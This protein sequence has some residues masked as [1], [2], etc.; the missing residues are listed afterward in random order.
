MEMKNIIIDKRK[1]IINEWL[2]SFYLLG[3]I[4]TSDTY[5]RTMW[6]VNNHLSKQNAVYTLCLR[7]SNLKEQSS[8]IL[9]TLVMSGH[10]WVLRQWFAKPLN[11]S[12]IELAIEWYTKYCTT[13]AFPVDMFTY[14]LNT[15][16][17]NDIYLPVN[18]YGLNGGQTFFPGIPSLVIE[19]PGSLV[20]FLEPQLCR[21]FASVLWTTKTMILNDLLDS[22]FIELG[23]RCDIDEISS[24]AKLLSIY[25]GNGGKQVLTSCDI[26]EFMFPELFKAVGTVGHEFLVSLQD[27][28][29]T[30]K[31]SEFAAMYLYIS[32]MQ[33]AC[34]PTDTVDPRPEFVCSIS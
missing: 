6:S 8:K 5:K 29:S 17:G 24:I 28:C 31:E 12:N 23:Y 21:Y 1:S 3:G 22:N 25:I 7:E 16:V 26:S 14:L 20:S 15:Q 34:F 11:R 27:D 10:E 30:L 18:I 32:K 4:I 33:N 9:P 13:K 2:S 19:G